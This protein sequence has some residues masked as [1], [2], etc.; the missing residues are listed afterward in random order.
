MFRRRNV[1]YG[2]LEMKDFSSRFAAIGVALSLSVPTAVPAASMDASAFIKSPTLF[3]FRSQAVSQA[4]IDFPLRPLQ[5]SLLKSKLAR[6]YTPAPAPPLQELGWNL[7]ISVGLSWSAA[8]AFPG[9]GIWAT[10]VP[11]NFGE[12]IF[13]YFRS[14]LEKDPLPS[15]VHDVLRETVRRYLSDELWVALTNEQ[16]LV[17]SGNRSA[18]THLLQ[19]MTNIKNADLPG[20]DRESVWVSESL[21]ETYRDLVAAYAAP[22]PGPKFIHL[23]SDWLERA[24]QAPKIII[25]TLAKIAELSLSE[26][27]TILLLASERHTLMVIDATSGRGWETLMPL[28]RSLSKDVRAHVAI[29][30]DFEPRLQVEAA[31]GARGIS[32]FSRPANA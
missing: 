22:S 14:L 25:V 21:F 23:L 13:Q 32:P 19:I 11:A 3:T 10:V 18:L 29:V 1:C 24:H 4:L 27:G 5:N 6:R 8:W 17:T 20:T 16:V 28:L 26:L 31:I 7:L 12:V 30:I 2:V 9:T 15:P